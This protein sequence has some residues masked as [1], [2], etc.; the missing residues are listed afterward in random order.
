MQNTAFVPSTMTVS[1]GTTITWTNKDS[2]AHTVTS[3]TPGNPN[4]EFASGNIGQ[5]GTFA[6]TFGA[7][8]VF[9]FYCSI[10]QSMTG[11]I[12]VQ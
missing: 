1:V 9:H 12:T 2:F 3:G 7:V 5:N 4:G 8:G 6:H 11:T 10:H